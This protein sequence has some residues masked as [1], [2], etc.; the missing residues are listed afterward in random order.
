MYSQSRVSHGFP[1]SR[2]PVSSEIHTL[3]HFSRAYIFIIAATMVK[4][5]YNGVVIAESSDTA[6]VEGNHYFPPDSV[7]VV[8]A[9]SDT[10]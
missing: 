2:S 5:T 4:A 9:I 7:K 8:L 3:R 1:F 10:T 6:F